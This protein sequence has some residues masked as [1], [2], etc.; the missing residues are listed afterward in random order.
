MSHG[1]EELNMGTRSSVCRGAG[2]GCSGGF[3][4][5]E[6]MTAITLAGVLVTIGVPNY[7]RVVDNARVTQAI[8]DIR[9]L[10]KDIL[11][12]ETVNG[13][14][15][16]NLDEINRG[17]LEDPWGN[18]YRYL[19]LAENNLG[20]MRKDRWLVPLNSSYDLYSCGKD[21]KTALPIT[22]PQSFDDIIRANDG[23]FIGL[24]SNY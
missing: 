21:G 8:G 2:W 6:L 15:P 23:G 18:P 1:E 16:K 22:A 4:L 12:F 10:E 24:A 17:G 11:S 20:S 19:S 3:T 14:A 9:S 5:L 13:R 7:R